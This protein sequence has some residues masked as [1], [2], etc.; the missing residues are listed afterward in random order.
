[1]HTIDFLVDSLPTFWRGFR[2]T[3]LLALASYAG[4]LALGCV[5]AVLRISPA[6]PARAAGLAYVEWFRNVPL[7]VLMFVAI[8]CLPKLGVRISSFQAALLVLVMYTAAQVCEALRA[9]INAVSRGQAEAGRALG[10]TFR[11]NLRHVILP[12][13]VRTVVPPLG[14]IFIA[15]VKNT[16]VASLIGV[17]ELTFQFGE[18]ARDAPSQ[19]MPLLVAIALCYLVITIPAGYLVARFERRSAVAR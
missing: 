5:L 7:L 17:I 4:A 8:L 3:L 1:V 11:Q 14:S 13:A 6:A 15:L 9:G 12:Q 10:L 18:L 2:T 19:I 16:A